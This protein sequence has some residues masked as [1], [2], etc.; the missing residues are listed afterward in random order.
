MVE[1]GGVEPPSEMGSPAVST[2]IG[3]GISLLPS[4][5]ASVNRRKDSSPVSYW[6]VGL[7]ASQPD[8]ITLGTRLG[9]GRPYTSLTCCLGSSEAIVGVASYLCEPVDTQLAQLRD[10]TSAST[11]PSKPVHPHFPKSNAR[12][13][14]HG[15]YTSSAR[16]PLNADQGNPEVKSRLSRATHVWAGS[17]TIGQQC[18]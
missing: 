1:V 7:N 3:A 8:S 11:I 10:A 16:F 15:E 6:R 4:A 2:S 9:P 13:S 5:A 12:V 14:A 17:H 18:M